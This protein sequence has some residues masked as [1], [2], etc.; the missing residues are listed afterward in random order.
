MS[1]ERDNIPL[2]IQRKVRQRCGFGCVICGFPLYEYEHMEEWAIVK[3]HVAEEITLLCDQHHREKTQGLLPKEVVIKENKNPYNLREGVS[4]PYNLH[5]YGDTVEVVFGNI[6]FRTE[7]KELI[8]LLIDNTPIIYFVLNDNHFL[9]NMLLFDE[10]NQLIFRIQ[11]N[12]LVYKT[13]IWDIQLVGRKLTIRQEHRNIL[14]EIIFQTPN[15]VIINKGRF[16]L[17]G[18]EVIISP[19]NILVNKGKDSMSRFF[20]M[21]FV[22]RIGLTVGNNNP[23]YSYFSVL[24]IGKVNRYCR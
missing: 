21:S 12:V 23:A 10:Y 13:D 3:R 22:G 2:P 8:P 6:S 19:D 15:K 20:N 4:K 24:D 5:Y 7:D 17:N 9:L 1:Q 14:I 11:D 18:I 16:L